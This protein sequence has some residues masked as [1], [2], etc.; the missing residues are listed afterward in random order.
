[1]ATTNKQVTDNNK[2]PLLLLH[3]PARKRATITTSAEHPLADDPL[4]SIATEGIPEQGTCYVPEGE[5]VTL[6]ATNPACDSP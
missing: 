5:F 2:Q 3:L 1:M 4:L 6:A